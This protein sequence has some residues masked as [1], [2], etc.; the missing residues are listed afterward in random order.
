MSDSQVPAQPS[1]LSTYA[2]IRNAALQGFADKGVA[3]TSIRDV[4]AAAGLS[5]GLVQH[6]FGTKARLRE[7]VNEYVIAVAVETFRD[8]AR[9]G[10]G[11]GET[12]W[13]A[14]GDVVTAWVRDNA[15]AL[16]YL[17]R[18][19]AEGDEEAA[20][21]FDALIEIARTGW[22][23]P[24]DRDGRL[25]ADADRDWAALHVVVFNLACVFFEPAISRHLP[26]PF[27]GP[28]QLHRWN[29]ATTEL[30]RRALST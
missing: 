20:K 28:E 22:L 7:A 8:L 24:L 23:A 25:R 27:F 18:A 1:D 6:H 10:D 19:L 9:D 4:A 17:A 16:R 2:R 15:V 21:I 29:T 26:G 12:A 13:G 14:M 30:Y 3:A 11:D 5:P